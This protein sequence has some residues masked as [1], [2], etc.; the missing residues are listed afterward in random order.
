M[1]ADIGLC[2]VRSNYSGPGLYSG[3]VSLPNRFNPDECTW[4]HG[5]PEVPCARTQRATLALPAW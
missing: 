2:V 5:Q 3:A 4:H 1:L